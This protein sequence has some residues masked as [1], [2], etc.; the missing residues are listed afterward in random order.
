MDRDSK[1]CSFHSLSIH[2][3]CVSLRVLAHRQKASNTR[4]TTIRY[5]RQPEKANCAPRGVCTQKRGRKLDGENVI[6]PVGFFQSIE[7]TV[8]GIPP[9]LSSIQTKPDYVYGCC[10]NADSVVLKSLWQLTLTD[11]F[12]VCQKPMEP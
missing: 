5:Q 2:F 8:D 4:K 7:V 1:G 11:N 3:F 12:L 6:N 10:C 9:P